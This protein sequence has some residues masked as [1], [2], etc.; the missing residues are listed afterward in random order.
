MHDKRKMNFGFQ[1][2]MAYKSKETK[3]YR[4]VKGGYT[5]IV[6]ID[7]RHL[8]F[9]KLH[10]GINLFTGAGFSVL[11]D[12]SGNGLPVASD[13]GTDLCKKLKKMKPMQ[14]IWKD[15]HLF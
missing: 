13:L 3:I 11:K 10:T 2:M 12:S 14:L 5:R 7:S 4:L 15:C 1:S 8:F 9:E 6:P